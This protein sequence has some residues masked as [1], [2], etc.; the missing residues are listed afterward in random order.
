MKNVSVIAALAALAVAALAYAALYHAGGGVMPEAKYRKVLVIGID[1]MDP[2]ITGRLM[3]EGRLPNFK[4]LSESGAYMALD[5]STPPHSPVAWTSMATGSNPGRHNIFD[6]IR[7]DERTRMPELSL[8]K[9]KSGLAGTSY[10]SY[11]KAT[12]FWR[13]A[14]AAGVKTTVIRWPVTFPPEDVEGDM[15]SGLGVPDIKGFLSGYTYYTSD[16]DA[17]SEKSSNR[18]VTLDLTA[19]SAATHV[20]GPKTVKS[21]EVADV[22]AP[23]RIDAAP[24]KVKLTVDGLEYTVEDGRWSGW[25]RAKF[26][27]SAFKTAYGTFKAYVSSAEPLRMYVTAVQIDPENPVVSISKPDGYSAQLAREIGLY[28]T[29]G[30]PE[31]TDGYV[32]GKLDKNAFIAQIVDIEGE[33]DRMF[34]RELD[35]FLARDAGILAFVYDSSDRVQHVTWN[36]SMLEGGELV[37]DDAI[38]GY[39]EGKDRLIGEVL[40]RLDDRT[41]LLVVS[42]HGFTSYEKGVSM[43]RWLVENGYM[44]LTREPPEGQDG[45]LFEYVDWTKTKAYSLGFNSVYVN[46]RGREDG[47]I[48]EDRQAF[49]RE[50]QGRLEAMTDPANGRRPVHRA[51][52]REDIY[53]GPYVKDAPDIVVGYNPGYRMAWQ[54]AIG[55]LTP[56]VFVPN[57]KKWRGDHLVDPSYVPGVLFSNARLGSG[58]ASQTDVA[59]T[60][61]AAVGVRKP[62]GMDGKSLLG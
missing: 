57:T 19:G 60:I 14:S 37:L 18:V 47:G 45:A 36:Q 43:N 59:P 29:L 42:D 33:R 13:S 55:G 25:V 15:L 44:A 30:M 4:R 48:V 40:P 3:A 7:R 49:A 56:E 26:K 24:G 8:A 21:G 62:D 11:V 61:L 17:K 12:P 41:L 22:T 20:W 54:T 34:R 1:G 32:D 38:A 6:F 46:A 16:K 52:L 58:S 2:K 5:T 31:E 27:V 50:L 10:E 53:S 23:M 28:Y 39:Y 51:Y 9:T 35:L